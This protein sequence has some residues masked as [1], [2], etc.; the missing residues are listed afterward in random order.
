[1]NDLVIVLLIGSWVGG[2]RHA[3]LGFIKNLLYLHL[4]QSSLLRCH[5]PERTCHTP[6]I[7]IFFIWLQLW[8]FF[9]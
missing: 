7:Q 5:F 6:S 2:L 3:I 9:V 4:R 1:M 8:I